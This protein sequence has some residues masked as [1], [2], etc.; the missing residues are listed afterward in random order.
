MHS[1]TLRRQRGAFKL[2]WVAFCAALFA[3]LAMAALLS[4]RYEKN[5]FAEGA[6]RLG[7]MAASSP[8]AGVAA[9]SGAAPGQ[10]GGQLRKCRIDGK[11]VISNV[12]C[13]DS[14]PSSETMKLTVT[15]G[16]EAPKAPPPPPAPEAG[17]NPMLDKAIEKQLR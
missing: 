6:A 1:T 11:T 2:H 13:L 4:W 8:A 9:K 10:A 17:S 7:A 5:L 15:R 16:V 14:N 12:A 3:A